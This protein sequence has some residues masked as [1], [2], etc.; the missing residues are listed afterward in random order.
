MHKCDKSFSLAFECLEQ[1]SIGCVLSYM[2][3]KEDVGR[4]RALKTRDEV[5]TPAAAKPIPAL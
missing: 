2:C 4:G 1:L 5:Q 3:S